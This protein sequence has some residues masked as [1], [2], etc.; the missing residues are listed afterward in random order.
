LNRRTLRVG[1]IETELIE[2]G[3]GPTLL[4][5]HAGE[6]PDAVLDLFLRKLAMHFRVIAPWHPGFG[7]APRP[8]AFRDVGD[9]VYFHLEL[10]G[11]LGLPAPGP[12]KF[13]YLVLVG[14]G[15]TEAEGHARARKRGKRPDRRP[16]RARQ[17][18][19]VADATLLT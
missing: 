3:T 16:A 4:F 11:A 15:R 18:R 12:D 6:G 13:G 10:A 5:L 8:P 1:A 19:I 2:T 9:L 14:I 17:G 7:S